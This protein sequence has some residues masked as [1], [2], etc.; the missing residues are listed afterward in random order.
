[1]VGSF[2]SASSARHPLLSASFYLF[3]FLPPHLSPA[4]ITRSRS[5]RART[6]EPAST[7]T[8][9]PKQQ[10]ASQT[11]PLTHVWHTIPPELLQ[12]VTSYLCASVTASHADIELL[13]RLSSV[14]AAWHRTVNCESSMRRVCVWSCVGTAT[15]SFDQ[16]KMAIAGRPIL[17]PALPAA[18]SSLR[19]L[20]SLLLRLSIRSDLERLEAAIGTLQTY[21][22]LS[23]LHLDLTS[24]YIANSGDSKEETETEVHS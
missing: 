7:P 16:R 19:H 5:K 10:R 12:H 15:V 2:W 1:M 9:Q 8:R 23:G 6:S 21:R 24:A 18:L 20:R 22:H 14:C 3:P 4:M 11:T 13:F 17:A